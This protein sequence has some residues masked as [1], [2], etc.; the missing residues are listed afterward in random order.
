MSRP[1]HWRAR[2]ARPEER[3]ALLAMV[4][5]LQTYELRF[6]PNRA[7]PAAMAGP[8]LDA[9]DAWTEDGCGGVLVAADVD[10]DSALG[11]FVAFGVVEERGWHAA[12]QNRRYGV[13]SDLYV[14]DAA[15][16][17]GVARAL[18][19]ETRKRLIA[20]GIRRLEVTALYDNGDARA[21]YAALGLAP[22]HV[23]YAE[24]LPRG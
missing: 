20:E 24:Q 5:A 11:G 15:R 12:H 19:R 7:P 2:P 18:V 14:R 3:E 4:A 6:E 10:T 1:P 8:H 22:S 16:R 23:T 9:L 21:A 17:Q 13:I